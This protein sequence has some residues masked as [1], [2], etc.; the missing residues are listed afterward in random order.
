ME[1]TKDDVVLV[2]KALVKDPNLSTT[3]KLLWITHKMLEEDTGKLPKQQEIADHCGVSLKT[4]SYS[5]PQLE[6]FGW[7]KREPWRLFGEWTQKLKE[8]KK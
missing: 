4:I 8:H 1:Q 7:A 6:H 3:A 2:P 5:Y